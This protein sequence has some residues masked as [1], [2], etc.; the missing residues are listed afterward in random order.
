MEEKDE[1]NYIRI[2]ANYNIC[3]PTVY[4]A[5]N[6]V[7]SE[8]DYYTLQNLWD[9]YSGSEGMYVADHVV[10]S[11]KLRKN[12]SKEEL[13]NTFKDTDGEVEIEEY[14]FKDELISK[15]KCKL[16]RAISNSITFEKYNKTKLN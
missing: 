16:L 7:K 10:V 6:E 4:N 13:I 1:R 12:I 5:P 9:V 3:F 15:H 14:N 2:F 8:E 11:L